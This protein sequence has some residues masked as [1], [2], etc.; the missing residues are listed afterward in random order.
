MKYMMSYMKFAGKLKKQI[1]EQMERLVEL[2][3]EGR[4]SYDSTG[5]FFEDG[6]RY[7]INKKIHTICLYPNYGKERF[8]KISP[9]INVDM[10]YDLYQCKISMERITMNVAVSILQHICDG[11]KEEWPWIISDCSD[12]GLDEIYYAL[13]NPETNAELLE[14]VPHVPFLNLEVVFYFMKGDDEELNSTVM[15][16]LQ[17]L[18]RSGHSLDELMKAACENTIRDFEVYGEGDEE[19][20]MLMDSSAP[21]A[22]YLLTYDGLMDDIAGDFDDNM[23]VMAFGCN[24]VLFSAEK[25]SDYLSLACMAR[26]Y[27]H[28]L[29]KDQRLSPEL[30]YYDRE[31]R[32]LSI[33]DFS[34]VEGRKDV[35]SKVAG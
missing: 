13:V 29:E 8:E 15:Y 14:C 5:W 19:I 17:M 25:H 34:F 23:F 26:K 1:K 22:S 6:M 11:P 16:D 28:K 30:Y 24:S 9:V 27:F 31:T 18:E 20:S 3:T 10:L 32:S 33:C 7:S 12:P 2:S 21:V 35:L 4:Q